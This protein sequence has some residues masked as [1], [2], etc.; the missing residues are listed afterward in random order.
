[1]FNLGAEVPYTVNELAAT[2]AAAMSVPNYPIEHLPP[3]LEMHT[4]YSDHGKAGRVFGAQ[5]QT[6]LETGIRKMAA[7]ARAGGVRS[8][9]PIQ[10]VEVTRHLPECWRRLVE[11]PV[12]I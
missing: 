11:P 9:R 6:S 5:A 10:G 7:W 4:A 3:R 1:V 2:V 8:S 12:T